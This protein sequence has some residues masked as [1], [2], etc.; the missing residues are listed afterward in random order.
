MNNVHRADFQKWVC[1]KISH[2]PNQLQT[3]Q[4]VSR[5]CPDTIWPTLIN[6]LLSNVKVKTDY[7][8]RVVPA[9]LADLLW[10]Q[11]TN[12]IMRTSHKPNFSRIGQ[13]MAEIWQIPVSTVHVQVCSGWS[14]PVGFSLQ[15]VQEQ[16]KDLVTAKICTPLQTW[17]LGN[18]ICHISA[19][20]CPIGLKFGLWL[21]LMIILTP[22]IH[23]KT[24]RVAAST[25]N[26]ESTLTLRLLRRPLIQ[27]GQMVSGHFL[28][29]PWVVCK[30]S[31]S[32]E[33]KCKT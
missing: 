19:A 9:I 26:M 22:C 20:F 30:W 12:I 11:G 8:F 7:T 28:L 10:R 24:A 13:K 32:W 2:G 23:S 25:L 16:L 14:K 15:R 29:S 5:K 21:V 31:G 17:T 33:K 18:L 3:T 6:G 4:G 27:V 1:P